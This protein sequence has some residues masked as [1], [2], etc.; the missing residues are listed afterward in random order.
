MKRFYLYSLLA[1]LVVF[2]LLYFSKQSMTR[3]QVYEMQFLEAFFIVS[4]CLFYFFYKR[5]F[6]DLMSLKSFFLLITY[7]CL[8]CTVKWQFESLAMASGHVI[9][10]MAIAYLDKYTNF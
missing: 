1:G 9:C 5:N 8:F 3:F 6:V 2:I 10:Y 4:S 7:I